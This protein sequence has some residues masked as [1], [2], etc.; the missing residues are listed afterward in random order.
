MVAEDRQR[1]IMMTATRSIRSF[2]SGLYQRPLS[3]PQWDQK[4]P[5]CS[6]CCEMTHTLDS[7]GGMEWK[8][9]KR[10]T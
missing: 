7:G 9:L 5:R 1:L 3:S 4:V 2:G 8:L 6:E 10:D